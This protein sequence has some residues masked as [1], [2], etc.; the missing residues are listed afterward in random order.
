MFLA[1]RK[2]ILYLQELAN[3]CD[4]IKMRHPSLMP[5]GLNLI[6]WDKEGITSDKA[7]RCIQFYNEILRRANEI[8]NPMPKVAVTED[9][10]DFNNQY[11]YERTDEDLHLVCR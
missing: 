1:T 9:L 2:Q 6:D 11:D 7:S 3:R 4:I 8:L 10:P 5:L